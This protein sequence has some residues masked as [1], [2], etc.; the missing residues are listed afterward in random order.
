VLLQSRRLRIA[1]A[2]PEVETLVHE[3]SHFKV[4]VNLRSGH[5]SFECWRSRDH[6]DQVLAVALAAWLGERSAA[7]ETSVEDEAISLKTYYTR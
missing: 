4:K 2:L 6:D 3:L 1:G 7:Q 5:E